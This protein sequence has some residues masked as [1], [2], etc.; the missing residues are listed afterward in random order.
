V[1]YGMGMSDHDPGIHRRSGVGKERP[2]PGPGPAPERGAQL[3]DVR[4]QTQPDA[5]DAGGRTSSQ[6]QVSEA[7]SGFAD[8]ETAAGGADAVP[9]TH[10]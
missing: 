1:I 5:V 8:A 3:D 2:G 10:G 9:D 7:G 6:G 4:E